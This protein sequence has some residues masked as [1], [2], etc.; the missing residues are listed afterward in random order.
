[1]NVAAKSENMP[2]P[3]DINDQ[4][5]RNRQEKVEQLLAFTQNEIKA[6]Y[7][8][9]KAMMEVFEDIEKQ[10]STKYGTGAV[11]YF[12]EQLD[13]DQS[14][15]Y[16][17]QEVARRFTEEEI[18]IICNTKFV[19]WSHVL[20]AVKID[21]KKQRIKAL[22][23]IERMDPEQRKISNF[24][25]EI[26]KVREEQSQSKEQQEDNPE[27]STSKVGGGGSRTGTGHGPSPVTPVKRFGKTSETLVSQ[28]KDAIIALKE[29]DPETEKARANMTEAVE[30]SLGIAT[31]IVEVLAGWV[32]VG[33][34]YLFNSDDFTKA[35]RDQQKDRRSAFQS[36]LYT[37]RKTV[38]ITDDPPPSKPKKAS[39]KKKAAPKSTEKSKPSQPNIDPSEM[40]ERLR[41]IREA[42]AK[43]D[44]DAGAK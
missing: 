4:Q 42:T 15:L 40:A 30:I 19:L 8:R 43:A 39:P 37:F 6:R 24:R 1:M 9:G 3:R 25:Q 33:E 26:L 34:P 21:D 13:I 22:K 5:K 41:K 29:F 16:R 12:A 36:A 7:Q 20:V 11:S 18:E 14:M 44:K 23:D 32:E 27:V 2:S 28:A 35:R 10:G 38:E 31:E 17:E